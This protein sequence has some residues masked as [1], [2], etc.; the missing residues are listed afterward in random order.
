MK[1]GSIAAAALCCAALT[2]PAAG[3]GTPL[4]A[5]APAPDFALQGATQSGVLPD[6]VRLSDFAGKTVVLAFFYQAR[7]K[8]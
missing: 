8:G 1:P 2:T 3:Q 6:S 4:Q 7:T 5:G